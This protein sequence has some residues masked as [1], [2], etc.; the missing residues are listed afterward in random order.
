MSAGIKGAGAVFTTE[1][2]VAA[3]VDHSDD[4][5]AIRLTSEDRDDSDLTFAEAASGDL[6]DFQLV[7]TAIQST[8]AT[9]LWRELWDNPGDEFDV[10][11]GPH[12]NAVPSVSQPHFT[13]TVKATGKPEVG[14]EAAKNGNRFDFEYTYDVTAGPVLDDGA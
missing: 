5:K 13:M 10:V 6:K 4:L 8:E 14:G 2:G 9:S 7:V 1:L 12:G 11:Y 3:A